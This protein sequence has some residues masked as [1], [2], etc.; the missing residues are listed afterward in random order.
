[1]SRPPPR[2]C[3]LSA[4]I[5]CPDRRCARLVFSSPEQFLGVL[6]CDR[7]KGHFWVTRLEAGSVRAQLVEDY[8]GDAGVADHMMALFDLPAEIDRPMY[9][10]IWL[11]H[12]ESHAYNTDTAPA[13]SL[14]LFRRLID[15]LQRKAS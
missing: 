3:S 15:V 9:W 2:F 11:T 12:K 8:D 5:R 10:H 14:R 6:Q 13:R 4:A 1:M 7:C